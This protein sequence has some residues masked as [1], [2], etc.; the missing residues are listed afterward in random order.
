M[1]RMS[2]LLTSPAPTAPTNTN[3]PSAAGLTGSS[4][5][6]FPSP[7]APRNSAIQPGEAVRRAPMI[8]ALQ[9]AH[10]DLDPSLAFLNHGSYGACPRYVL[11]AQQALRARMEADPVRFYKVDLENLMDR[12]RLALGSFLRC[13]PDLLA[14]FPNATVALC[15][16]LR[17][18]PFKPGDE[19]ITNDH[20][21]M[22]GTNELERIAHERSLKV[23][24]PTLP[25]PLPESEHEAREAIV[26]A[27]MAAVT[28]RTRMLLVSHIT[29]CTSLI[30]P[31]ERLAA[32]CK[33]R[34][35]EILIDGTHAV[36]QIPVDVASLDP[37]FY[38]G[39]GHKWLS[40][41]KGTGFLYVRRDLAEGF[42]PLSLS[43]RAH[44]VRPER[45]LFLRDFDY[46]GTCDYSN[47]L[48][49]PECLEFYA[50]LLPGGWNEVFASNHRLIM[51][52]RQIIASIAGLGLPC[53]EGLVGTMATLIIPEP[54]A[55][56]A[57][58][59]TLYDDPLQDA[60]LDRHRV[61]A[62]VWRLGANGPRVIRFSAQVYNHPEQYAH[63]GHALA[64]ELRREQMLPRA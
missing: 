55:G 33:A 34:G 31:V 22:S 20:E 46:V 16:A 59:R 61:V 24:K 21:Y 28:P 60:L 54:P 18:F 45:A 49:L 57:P 35:I 47:V 19:I 40:S 36:G 25:Y 30:L 4:G 63:A 58:R 37:A 38:V 14:P 6:V 17:N 8:S 7:I 32:E 62:P 12:V 13:D 2:A 64:E 15:T 1:E 27:I 41:P 5:R 26:A 10:W 50:T 52:G 11:A 23:V 39:S 44:K 43:S 9:A 3:S 48:V 56:V 29:S 53:P 42:R 51:Q